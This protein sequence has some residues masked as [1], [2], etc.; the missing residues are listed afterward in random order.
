MTRISQIACVFLFVF[1]LVV[2]CPAQK[3]DKVEVF[4][5]ISVEID[6]QSCKD[7]KFGR[8]VISPKPELPLEAKMARVGG[9][10]LVSVKIDEK[11]TA[12]EFET[13]SGHRLLQNAAADAA[14]KA[15]FSPT[16]CN[17]AAIKA[18][19]VLTY[20]FVPFITTASY[21]TPLKIEEFADIRNDSPYYEAV[22][23]LTESYKIA[24]GYADK[25]FYADAPLTHG[26]FAQFLRLTLDLVS[27][28]AG[29]ANKLPR[30]I[31]LFYPHNPQKIA[32]VGV[33]KNLKQNAPFYES[34]KTLLLKYDIVLTNN[35]NEFPGS[36]HLTNDEVIN[37]W[38]K[39]F[40]SD[41][42]PVNFAPVAENDRII[43]RGEFA[44]FLQES[45]QVLTY[46]VLP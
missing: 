24:F 30:E 34:V 36:L 22:L 23:S 33:I 27:A 18:L 12:S 15:R 8:A 26:D 29:N 31:G 14:R 44:L 2:G 10:V 3:K 1:V 43:S 19:G 7:L 21:F 41:T 37:W 28:R 38:S 13:I 46:K 11:G 32:S 35:K 45:L 6:N 4:S 17:G 5:K 9:T 40:G 16:T 25:R 42:I 20:N 39:I